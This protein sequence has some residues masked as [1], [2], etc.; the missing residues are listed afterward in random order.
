MGFV[1][2]IPYLSAAL[3]GVWLTKPCND[4]FGRRGCIF[5]SGILL[6]ISPLASAFTHN[7]QSLLGCRI[8]MGVGMGLK[9]SSSPVFATEHSPMRG[10][11]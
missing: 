11:S 9:G 6:L 3:L 4:Y 8:I 7:W 10:E 5:I 2:S 1:N